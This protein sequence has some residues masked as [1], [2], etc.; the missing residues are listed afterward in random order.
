[1]NNNYN[2]IMS[3]IIFIALIWLVYNNAIINGINI[4]D[5]IACV[6]FLI[7]NG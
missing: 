5:D 1:M 4:D 7:D 3:L 2:N 6:T